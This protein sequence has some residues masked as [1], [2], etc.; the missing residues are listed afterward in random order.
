VAVKLSRLSGGDRVCYLARIKAGIAVARS[1]EAV[2]SPVQREVARLAARGATVAEIAQSI[3]RGSETVRSHLS[4]AYRRLG[5]STRV[6]LARALA[7]V[8][9]AAA[10]P[11][12]TVW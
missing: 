6:D 8:P 5:V 7:S 11:E 3:G 1:E 9:R 4:A 10:P 2:L 12:I